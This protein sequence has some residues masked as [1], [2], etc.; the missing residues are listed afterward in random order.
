MKLEWDRLR[1]IRTWDERWV[2]Q[3]LEVIKASDPKNPDHI[4]TIFDICVE[5]GRSCRMVAPTRSLKAGSCSRANSVWDT[6][7]DYAI[8]Q[9]LSSNPATMEA[10]KAADLVAIMPGNIGEQADATQAYTQAELRGRRTR[11]RLPK[12]EWPE[13]WKARGIDEVFDPVVP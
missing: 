10:A 8:F 4:G 1:N 2:R 6:H 13:S 3:C 7:Y 11:V 12:H 9:D 5:K